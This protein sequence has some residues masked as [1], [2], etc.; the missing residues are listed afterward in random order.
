MVC[1]SI[2]VHVYIYVCVLYVYVPVS[3]CGYVCVS[4]AISLLFILF[5]CQSINFVLFLFVFLFCLHIC[6]L[7]REKE[8]L[9]SGGWGESEVWKEMREGKPCSEYIIW[10]QSLQF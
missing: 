9:E 1:M 4:H 7:K 10:K 8:C 2:S 3:V 5:A 6:F